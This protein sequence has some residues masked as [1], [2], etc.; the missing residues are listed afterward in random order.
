MSQLGEFARFAMMSG[1][2]ASQA[3]I[4]VLTKECFVRRNRIHGFVRLKFTL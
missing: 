2:L 3:L 1:S 4:G